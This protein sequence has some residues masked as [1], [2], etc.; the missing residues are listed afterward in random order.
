MVLVFNCLG[1]PQINYTVKATDANFSPLEGVFL[2][3]GFH[4]TVPGQWGGK[5]IDYTANSND[6]GEINVMGKTAVVKGGTLTKDGYY[7][8][9]LPKVTE[10]FN[11]ALN[12]W[13]PWG[14]E[15]GVILREK[16]KPVPMYAQKTQGLKFPVLGKP[17]G[18]DLEK[19]DWVA[20]YG[21]GLISDFIFKFHNDY[22]QRGKYLTTFDLSFSNPHDGVIKLEKENMP[23]S[24]YIWPY[25][26]PLVGYETSLFKL[27]FRNWYKEPNYD[28]EVFSQAQSQEGHHYIF[29]VRSKVDNSGNIISSNY[30]KIKGDFMISGSAVGGGVQFTYYFNP[31]GTPNLEFDP[32]KNLFKYTRKEAGRY[33]LAP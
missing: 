1:N 22:K 8:S 24:E 16:K 4:Q 20:P 10:S 17:V 13:E 31:D 14:Q 7:R 23:L 18:Y 19:G 12:R 2:D 28:E 32:K 33:T 30:G 26:A 27:T 6:Q 25:E 9:Y 21:K 15:V 11:R 5:D 29:R 3:T